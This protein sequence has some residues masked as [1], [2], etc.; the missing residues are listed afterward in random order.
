MSRLLGYKHWKGDLQD[1]LRVPGS[2][3]EDLGDTLSSTSVNLKSENSLPFQLDKTSK[4][5][6][7]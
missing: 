7:S 1:A 6:V 5:I 2:G 3:L 4:I